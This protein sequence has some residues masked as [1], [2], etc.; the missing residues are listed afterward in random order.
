ML[1]Y[2]DALMK[3]GRYK[4]AEKAFWRAYKLNPLSSRAIDSLYML[5]LHRNIELN[6]T[7]QFPGLRLP[8]LLY[9][10]RERNGGIPNAFHHLAEKKGQDSAT[11]SRASFAPKVAGTQQV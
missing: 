1:Q 10:T 8:P 2:G 11:G 6:E 3:L 7:Q 9:Q 4:K 5:N